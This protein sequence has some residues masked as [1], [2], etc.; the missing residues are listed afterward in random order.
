MMQWRDLFTARQKLGLLTL[1]KVITSLSGVNAAKDFMGMALSR[2]SDIFNALCQWESSK[3]QVRHLF[4]RQAIPILWDFAEGS[5]LGEQA[6]DYSVTLETMCNV[7]DALRIG[8]P[9]GQTS[10][11]DA[12]NLSLPDTSAAVWFTDPPYY[13]AIP[14]SDLSIS[15]LC[16]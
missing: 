11:A 7:V 6:G 8:A 14:Y 12:R 4:T 1:L 10:Q 9:P 2:Y 13:D 15:S 3:T 5:M 16:G